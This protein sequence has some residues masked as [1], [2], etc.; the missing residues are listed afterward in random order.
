MAGWPAA[1]LAGTSPARPVPALRRG[2]VVQPYL[3]PYFPLAK[4]NKR[5]QITEA[6]KWSDANFGFSAAQEPER[7]HSF[8]AP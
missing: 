1:M 5:R 6:I 8:A 2:R 7:P 3:V 4:R